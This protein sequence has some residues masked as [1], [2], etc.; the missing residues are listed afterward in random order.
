MKIPGVFWVVLIVILV[1]A[2]IPVL[3]QVFPSS[4]YA[5]SAILVVVLAAI[6]KT[7]EIVYRKQIDKTVGQPMAA[8]T[9][10]PLGAGEYEYDVAATPAGPPAIVRW[11]VG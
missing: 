1:P 2:L 7:V 4:T 5:W 6:T 10:R 8:A 3:Q 9:P 11:L